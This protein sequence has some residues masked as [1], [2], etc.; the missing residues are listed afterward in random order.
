M[1]NKANHLTTNDECT[2]HATLAICYQLAQSTLKIGFVLGK[3]W[4]RGGGQVLAQGA[5]DMAG[6]LAGCRKTLVCTCLG[7]FSPI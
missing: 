4:D 5:V 1:N 6:A 3:R 7:H 2:C